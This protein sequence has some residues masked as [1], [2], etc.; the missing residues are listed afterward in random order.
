[1]HFGAGLGDMFLA[2]WDVSMHSGGAGVWWGACHRTMWRLVRDRADKRGRQSYSVFWGTDAGFCSPEQGVQRGSGL[3]ERGENKPRPP[4]YVVA[5]SFL[6]FL[7]FFDQR[8]FRWAPS[9]LQV[10]SISST[11]ASQ[12]CGNHV[13]RDQKSTRKRWETEMLANGW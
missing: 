10:R 12:M 6:S 13:H 3:E 7:M 9:E 11:L 5:T 4:L 1:M 8:P 2:L